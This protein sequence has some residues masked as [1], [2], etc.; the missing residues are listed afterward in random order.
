MSRFSY[1][2]YIQNIS[3]QTKRFEH[4]ADS[5]L[6]QHGG[7]SGGGLCGVPDHHS[8]AFPHFLYG[9]LCQ[10]LLDVFYGRQ[11]EVSWNSSILFI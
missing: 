11:M 2:V 8:G 10:V 6:G 1:I 4:T 5:E 7:A 3:G 9:E